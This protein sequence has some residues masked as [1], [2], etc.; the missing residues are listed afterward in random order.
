MAPS[1]K[2]YGEARHCVAAGQTLSHIAQ[3]YFGTPDAAPALATLN[4]LKSANDVREGAV[5]SIPSVVYLLDKIS[6]QGPA[7]STADVRPVPR[8]IALVEIVENVFPGTVTDMAPVAGKWLYVFD[9]DTL[10][11]KIDAQRPDRWHVESK[12]F[13]KDKLV[14]DGR[15]RLP[16]GKRYS[17]FLSPMALTEDAISYLAK[18]L[19]DCVTVA[20]AD[21]GSDRDVLLRDCFEFAVL[22]H[23][24]TYLPKL[25]AWK[26]WT[27]DPENAARLFIAST[28]KALIADGDKLSVRGHLNSGEPEKYLKGYEDD[29]L[30]LR[31]P[32]EH[33]AAHVAALVDSHDARAIDMA[34]MATGGDSFGMACVWWASVLNE[35][36]QSRP[37]IELLCRIAN[38]PSRLPMK[39]IFTDQVPANAPKFQD[40]RYLSLAAIA[41]FEKLAPA[42]AE[43]LR[44]RKVDVLD[45]LTRYLTHLEKGP[46]PIIGSYRTVR[47]N[48]RKGRSLSA[49]LKQ[50]QRQIKRMIA[51]AS[52]AVEP[53][54]LPKAIAGGERFSK[55]LTRGLG[56][57]LV[58]FGFALEIG[59]LSSA[60]VEL[61]SADAY[62]WAG[63]IG[64]GADMGALLT[65]CA[66]TLLRESTKRMIGSVFGVIS[67]VCDC[68]SFARDAKGA[69]DKYDYN[70]GVGL[71]IAALGAAGVAAGS[72]MVLFEG[73]GVIAA[74]G[75]GLVVAIIG[76]AVIGVGVGLAYLFTDN[77]Y[78]SFS[79]V[80]FLGRSHDGGPKSWHWSP[81]KLPTTSI[82]SEQQALLCL[83]SSFSL[84]MK[85]DTGFY[86]TPGFYIEGD[87]LEVY[88]KES[89]SNY[90]P[91]ASLIE[92]NLAAGTIQHLRGI[93]P[94]A[95][96]RSRL[97]KGKD[98]RVESV[99]ISL[100][101]EETPWRPRFGPARTVRVRLKRGVTTVP[102][103]RDVWIEGIFVPASPFG[104]RMEA[105][106]LDESHRANL[107]ESPMMPMP[108][109]FSD[110]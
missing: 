103:E 5:L 107:R 51:A 79:E 50:P 4:G 58:S 2:P 32:A 43:M 82:A 88:A 48:I 49:H 26:R 39:Y 18:H 71:G 66:G 8:Q 77:V 37:G 89:F 22:E 62:K 74:T 84:S 67:G 10:V 27:N 69:A 30:R 73:L 16:K 7:R 29:E 100:D 36:R 45:L 3:L 96:G 110:Q 81:E 13:P 53:I 97:Q 63:L 46:K 54:V 61:E 80:C 76:A 95:T 20:H 91:N 21:T 109:V 108:K 99:F 23:S 9:G 6:G 60:I 25:A 47:D 40:V 92:V 98:G 56:P 106:S 93:R 57:A 1:T 101:E 42:V 78:E 87:V 94:L 38:D 35:M 104:N 90:A 34:A 68:I 44:K 75:W 11:V 12:V 64:A 28:L 105:S 52:K 19:K 83:L 31:L 41:V 65:E 85:S 70:R 24:I 59:N 15:V 86:I 55:A 72:L 17:F 33:A 102:P 14:I